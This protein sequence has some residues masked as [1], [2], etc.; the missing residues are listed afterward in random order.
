MSMKR[1]QKELKDLMSDPPANCSAGP[2]GDDL[3]HWQATIMG[4][5]DSPYAGGIFRLDIHFPQDYPFKPPKVQFTSKIY[6][7]NVN[8]N[9]AICLDILNSQWSPALTIAK[10]LLSISSLLT[11]PNAD[12]PLVPEIAQMLKQNKTKHDSVAREWTLKYCSQ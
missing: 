2:V 3:F 10:V 7:C 12:D 1:I 8:K 11:D 9:G 4:P 5:A 6:H